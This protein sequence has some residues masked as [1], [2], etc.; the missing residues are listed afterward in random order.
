MIKNVPVNTET[1][2]LILAPSFISLILCIWALIQISK[3]QQR[4]LAVTGLCMD[5]FIIILFTT[6]RIM[7]T[8]IF[9]T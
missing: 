4:G 6:W 2:I 3:K 5:V 7:V 1:L 9:K 8:I